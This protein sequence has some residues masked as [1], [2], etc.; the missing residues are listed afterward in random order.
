MK[1]K[2]LSQLL[3]TLACLAMTFNALAQNK[4]EVRNVDFDKVKTTTQNPEARFY[5]PKLVQ[6]FKSNDTTMNFEAYRDL[7]YG[8][9]FQEDYNPFRESE[10]SNIV[11]TL[12]YKEPHT[13]AECDSIE[14][15]AELALND[16][17]F[18]LD[19]MEYYIY[20][21]K[22]KKKHH[23][24]AVR[25]FRL[26]RLI[27]AIMSSGKGTKESPWVVIAPEHEYKIVNYLGYV[28]IENEE[29]APGVDCIKA[30]SQTDATKTKEF[31]FDVSRM[32]QVAA[33]KFPE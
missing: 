26:D 11:E 12:Y 1:I 8:Y 18:D 21:L 5:Y 16:N 10:Y 33:L 13:R 17:M 3:L 6:A 4:F 30:K 22:A 28:A 29:S 24:A 25:Q 23:T 19:Q 14:K 2:H 7:Y 15:Y 32:L 27:A 31:Y 9:I 20:A